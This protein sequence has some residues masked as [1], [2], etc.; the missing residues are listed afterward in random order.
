VLRSA[1]VVQTS[2][3]LSCGVDGVDGVLLVQYSVN[4]IRRLG[5]SSGYCHLFVDIDY[6]TVIMKKSNGIIPYIYHT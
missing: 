3:E 1:A 2:T 5:I 6:E 4:K